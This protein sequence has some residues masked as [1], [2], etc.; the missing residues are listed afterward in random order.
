VGSNLH[1][2]GG[3]LE[4]TWIRT[5]ED[6]SVRV[7]LRLPGTREGELVV[8]RGADAILPVRAAFRDELELL[9]RAPAPGLDESKKIPDG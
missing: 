3:A 2:S 7:K 9:V 1:V 4:T 8:A 6:G 5:E